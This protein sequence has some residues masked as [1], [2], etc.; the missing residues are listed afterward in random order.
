MIVYYQ[1]TPQEVI[2]KEEEVAMETAGATPPLPL[3]TF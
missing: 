3:P 1:N 2:N